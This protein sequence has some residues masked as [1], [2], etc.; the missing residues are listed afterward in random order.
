MSAQRLSLLN[1]LDGFIAKSRV[2][3]VQIMVCLLLAGIWV[4]TLSV[5]EIERAKEEHEVRGAAQHLSNIYA[6]LMIRALDQIDLALGVVRYACEHSRP[7]LALMEL[8]D[9]VLVPSS[10][11][12]AITV[13]DERGR[14]AASNKSDVLKD[15][16]QA[17]YF[18]TFRDQKRMGD[19]LYTEETVQAGKQ[20]KGMTFARRMTRPD[21]SF[22]GVVMLTVASE[23]LTSWYE[24]S[25]LGKRGVIGFANKM[26]Q[27]IVTQTGDQLIWSDPAIANPQRRLPIDQDTTVLTTSPWDGER[28]FMMSES[29]GRYPF[30]TMVGLSEAEQFQ[31]FEHKRRSYLI[32]A[33]V[34]SLIL[35]LFGGMLWR[36]DLNQSRS[37]KAQQ[38]YQ[39]ASEAS[40]DANFVLHAMADSSGK[41]YDFSVVDA[42]TH[43]LKLIGL[44]KA[45][46]L[47]RKLSSFIEDLHASEVFV[48][49]SKAVRTSI[50][51]QYEWEN[52]DERLK[53][54]WLSV[55]VVPVPDGIVAIL[56]DISERKRF[57]NELVHRNVELTT[58]NL[59]LSQ[60]NQELT[61]AHEQL[62]Q[63]E[64]LASIGLLAAGV[65]HEINNPI[66]FVLSNIGTLGEYVDKLLVLLSEYQKAEELLADESA[67]SK[68]VGCRE[69][70]ELDYLRED[71]PPLL[72]ETKDGISRVR[73]IVEDLKNFSHVDSQSEWKLVNLREGI[74]STLNIV[75][76]ELKYVAEV[77]KA[78]A[79]L[80]LVECLPSEINQVILNLLVN[81]GHAIGGAG[82]QRGHIT[83]RTGCDQAFAWIEVEDT[84]C[85]IAPEHLARIFD[86]FFTTKP[87]GK[88][89]G[90]GL[91][92]SYGIVKKHCGNI[93]VKSELGRG[94]CFRVSLPLRRVQGGN[95]AV[96][97]KPAHV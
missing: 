29:L 79:D 19:F 65:A 62:V 67:R 91:S 85:G 45:A 17:A 3:W 90:L 66:G 8:Q 83:L 9:S 93:E 50:L 46:L 41:I 63:S 94:T 40:L 75:N 77:H 73:K 59:N 33:A 24:A 38:T 30:V 74:E 26:G 13:I 20:V 5:I 72:K 89:T 22:A 49:L 86:P 2:V 16:S 55:Q 57:E 88:G 97:S 25:R 69:S 68:L 23:Y 10:L 14:V 1:L 92:L 28:R 6:A 43:A 60:L 53:A 56:H 87:V 39:A 80:P 76:N 15:H 52:T 7:S 35:C 42:N 18:L 78:Y 37:R 81:A 31:G 96:T 64:K 61:N 34:A 58:L 32:E 82:G 27:L 71:I 12:F 11:L 48:A 54:N 36:M 84:G 70:V 4:T 51:G 95:E 21:G 44:S 47:G